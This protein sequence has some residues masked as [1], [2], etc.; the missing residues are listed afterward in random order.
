MIFRIWIVICSFLFSPNGIAQQMGGGM[1][2]ALLPAPPYPPDGLIPEIYKNQFVFL[3]PQTLD[4]V[5]A[6]VPVGPLAAVLGKRPEPSS[7][8]NCPVM[9]IRT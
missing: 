8:L 2:G 6:Y 3:D 1:S 9:S 4:I 5:L 7:V